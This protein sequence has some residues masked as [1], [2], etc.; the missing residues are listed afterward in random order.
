M[1]SIK[2]RE[3]VMNSKVMALLAQLNSF[4]YFT[5]WGYYFSAGF[6]A[7]HASRYNECAIGI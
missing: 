3:I 1:R 7:C 4:F 5:F 2:T 6:F